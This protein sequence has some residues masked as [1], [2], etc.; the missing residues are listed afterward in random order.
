MKEMCDKTYWIILSTF[1]AMRIFTPQWHY[2]HGYNRYARLKYDEH[3][4]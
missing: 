3:G 2:V 4:N 1:L